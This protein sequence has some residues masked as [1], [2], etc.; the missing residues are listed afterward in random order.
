MKSEHLQ[1]YAGALVDYD[2]ALQIEPNNVDYLNNRANLK[3]EY[4]GDVEGAMKDYDR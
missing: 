4:L 1:D 3:S 2:I